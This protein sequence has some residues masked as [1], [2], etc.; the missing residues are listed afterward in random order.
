[1]NWTKRM[2]V[3]GSAVPA[4]VLGAGT[5]AGAPASAAGN[6]SMN[7]WQVGASFNCNNPAVCGQPGG[8]GFWGW[9]EF[10][11]PVG[12]PA[13]TGTSGDFVFTGCG[14]G[15]YNGADHIDLAIDGW[16]IAPDTEPGPTQGLPV[17]WVTGG[18]MRYHDSSGNSYSGPAVDENGDPVSA[19]SPMDTGIPADPAHYT[20]QTFFGITAPAAAIQIQ[21]AYK[22]ASGH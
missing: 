10:D 17:F 11:Q 2:A 4:V 6:G 19:T 13:G 8:G 16:Y 9:A 21:V 22:P 5:L 18:T 15:A 20:T 14:H 1:M 7:V 12:S 3:A